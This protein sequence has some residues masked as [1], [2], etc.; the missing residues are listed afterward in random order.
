MSRRDH[1]QDITDRMLAALEGAEDEGW[2]KP[3]VSRG[4]GVAPRNAFT[5]RPYRGVNQL[6]LLLDPRNAADPRWATY[7]AAQKAG[8]QVR[9]GEKSTPV[10]LMKQVTVEETDD[11]GRKVEKVV[12]LLRTFNVFHASQFD[13][14]PPPQP[15]PVEGGWEPLEAAERAMK[16]LGADIRYGGDRAFYV[17]R[18]DRIQLPLRE[19]FPTAAGFYGTAFH[20][21]GHWTKGEDRVPRRDGVGGGGFGSDSYAREEIR[22]EFA[23]AFVLGALGLAGDPQL[24]CNHTAYIRDWMQ[25]LKEDRYEARRAA[26]D[27]QAI[28]D[29]L[30]PAAGE[31]DDDSGD[32]L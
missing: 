2:Q 31:G 24:S 32:P 1:Y 22:V 23:S 26:T 16:D 3:W 4:V 8:Y 17:P 19:D 15:E 28:A 7:R 9:R 25:V 5:G 6:L 14:E 11:D 13:L 10:Y 18:E 20:E 21:L 12:P 29:Y 27:A 30:L